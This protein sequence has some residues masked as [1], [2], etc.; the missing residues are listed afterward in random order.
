MRLLSALVGGLLLFG[1][2][3]V[4]AATYEIDSSHTVVGFKIRHMGL[5]FVR[6]SFL[7]F[8]GS[9]KFDPKDIAASSAEAIIEV[10]SI[11]T[12]NKKRDDHLR[13]DDFFNVA[14]FPEISFK[15]TSI[16][17]VAES[18]F[19]AVGDLTIHGVTKSVE[20]EIEYN[21]SLKDPW[22]KHRAGFSATT[23]IDRQEFGLKWSKLLETGGLVVGNEVK[24]QLEVEGVRKD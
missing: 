15:T 19:I 20:L 14:K 21:G 7:S 12:D 6:G 5:S 8:S 18:S 13:S 9:F 4:Q 23:K 17:D 10:S 24:I 2:S 3:V 16:K 11:D 22:G 1:A